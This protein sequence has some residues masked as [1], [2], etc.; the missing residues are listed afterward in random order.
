MLRQ[1]AQGGCLRAS[2]RLNL[3]PNCSSQGQA[4]AI[5]KRNWQTSI[6]F[7]P[8]EMTRNVFS[9]SIT[10]SIDVTLNAR[11]S[12][13]SVRSDWPHGLRSLLRRE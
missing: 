2:A 12:N 8:P 1:H 10:I 6:A 13:Y 3:P 5:P 4:T 11:C 9:G 7:N